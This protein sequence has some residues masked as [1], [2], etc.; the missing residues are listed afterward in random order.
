MPK[1]ES[2]PPFTGG[3]LERLAQALGRTD[4]GLTGSEIGHTLRQA[5]IPD[6][7]PTNTKWKRL[8]N[9]FVDCQNRSQRG[10][11][12]LNFIHHALQ[13]ARYVGA[14]AL[15]ESRREEIN[16]VLAFNGLQFSEAGKFVRVREART[17][18]EAQ[19]RAN[20]LR[21]KLKER[22]VHADVLEFC[23]AELLEDNYFHAVLEATKSIAAKL[24]TRSGLNSDCADLVD[25]ALGGSAPRLQ[26][27]AFQTASERSEQRGF[28]N[29]VKG[30]FGTFRNPTAHE[31]RIEWQMPE[32]DA[33]DLLALAS[34]VH[35]RL[36][37]AI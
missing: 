5:R 29:L 32:E 19:R 16:N 31:A 21:K 2:V 15:F 8:Y 1:S 14:Q 26:I 24:R 17:L 4:G 28:V 30:V 10:D 12:V 7:D 11:C 33:L 25:A 20:E 35:R 22:D 37:K 34:Y 27:N 9:A 6:V 13:P 36:D 23:R 18:T 3:Q